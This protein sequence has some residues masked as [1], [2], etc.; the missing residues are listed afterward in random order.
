[1]TAYT[2]TLVIIAISGRALAQSARRGGWRPRVIDA[3]GDVD[4]LACA[5]QVRA[6]PVNAEGVMDEKALLTG[7]AEL[8]LAC[9]QAGLIYGSG[10][11]C[12]PDLLERLSADYRIIGNTPDVLRAVKDPVTFAAAL[13]ALGIPCPPI[14]FTSPEDGV[15]PEMQVHRWLVKCATG[16]GGG[17]VRPWN[18]GQIDQDGQYFQRY[19]A[20][21]VISALFAADGERALII[22][23]NTQRVAGLASTP[24]AYAGATNRA[25]LTPDQ[26]DIVAGYV[27]GLSRAFGLRG[28]NGLDFILYRGQPMVLEINPRPTAACELYEPDTHNGM[29]AMHVRACDGVLPDQ[30]AL[31]A[32]KVRAHAIVYAKDPLHVPT[33]VRWPL[34]CRDIPAAG[35]TIAAGEPV[36]SIHAE[37]DDIESVERTVNARRDRVLASLHLQ[38]A[39]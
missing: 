25:R 37:G 15:D 16:A 12:M 4:T 33:T 5:D 35:N 21:P 18:G 9:P 24:F 31:K 29:V 39:A 8:T 3:F 27:G 11:E 32:P 1:M 26:R 22:G 2:D 34:W 6:A 19:V 13:R 20:G 17:H 36:C 10:G 7:L 23:Y 14:R 30:A 28:L 38:F